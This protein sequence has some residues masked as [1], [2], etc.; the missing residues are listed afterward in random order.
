MTATLAAGAPAAEARNWW[1]GDLLA[2][3]NS[4][5][6][7]PGDLAVTPAQVARVCALVADGTLTATLAKE[8]F[9][10]V[11][12]SGEDPDAVIAAKGLKQVSDVDALGAAVDE[13][14]S[15]QPDVAAKIRDGKVAAVGALVGAVMKA[16][17]GQA[18][19]AVVRT[20]VLERLGVTEG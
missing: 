1:L 6:V 2:R 20:L 7:D 17:R 3:A 5:E 4:A 18:N 8:V 19:A 16:T 13:A 11:L 10:G 12:D 15:A 9:A 14:I